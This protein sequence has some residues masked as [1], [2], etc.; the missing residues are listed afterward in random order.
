MSV[1]TRAV[2]IPVTNLV[3][4]FGAGKKWTSKANLPVVGK[5]YDGDHTIVTMRLTII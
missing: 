2:R 1:R 4:G 3:V 5:A